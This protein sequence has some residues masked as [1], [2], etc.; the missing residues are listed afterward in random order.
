MRAS[1]LIDP[2]REYIC[3]MLCMLSGTDFVSEIGAEIRAKE[4]HIGVPIVSGKRSMSCLDN[5]K[6]E[7]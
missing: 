3:C 2:R 6:E 1:P 5:P 4:I 7:Q